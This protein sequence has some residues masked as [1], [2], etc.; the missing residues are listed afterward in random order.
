[1]ISKKEYIIEQRRRKED[2]QLQ[3]TVPVEEE[4]RIM[5][6]RDLWINKDEWEDKDLYSEIKPTEENLK[7]DKKNQ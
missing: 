5:E 1:M 2:Q 7:K 6:Y 4:V 3:H